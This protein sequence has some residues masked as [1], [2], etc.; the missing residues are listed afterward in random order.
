MPTEAAERGPLRARRARGD[1]GNITAFIAVFAAAV[2]LMMGLVYD[3]G[4]LIASQRRAANVADG[5]ARA[6]AQALDTD[7]RRQG[8]T[9]LVPTEARANAD[10][11]VAAAGCDC[12]I[13][14]FETNGA[15]ATVEVTIE[16]EPTFF[17][18]ARSTVR[19][20]GTAELEEGITE[21]I[22]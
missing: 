8:E 14:H 19:E 7:L 5:A 11:Y 12:Q 22:P 4:R 3:G 2:L 10:A 13:S 15:Q 17:P 9:V 21:R 18:P 16:Y 1:A 6:A 20:R